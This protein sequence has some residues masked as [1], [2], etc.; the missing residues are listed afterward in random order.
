M[1]PIFH[2]LIPSNRKVLFLQEVPLRSIPV[3]LP[4]ERGESS[5]NINGVDLK[6]I[7]TTK[8]STFHKESLES[9]FQETREVISSVRR[10]PS[11]L[12]RH[13]STR[14]AL[15]EHVALPDA[16]LEDYYTQVEDHPHTH[17][18]THTHAPD[19]VHADSCMCTPPRGR[20][21]PRQGGMS[22]WGS[23]W[24]AGAPQQA[25]SAAPAS[26]TTRTTCSSS[27][28]WE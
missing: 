12:L 28:T 9:K 24:R 13:G 19:D 22:C 16:F 8:T 6:R 1:D 4:T 23:A 27:T 5:S 26:W 3:L 25:R 11:Q 17:I 21:G 2:V 14:A 18:H 15:L 10:L 20:C 7:E